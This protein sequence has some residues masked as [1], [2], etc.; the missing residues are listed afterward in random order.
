MS[1]PNTPDERSHPV[2]LFDGVCNLCESTVRFIITR[3]RR[4]QFRFAS[5]QS[6]VAEA[7]AAPFD[8]LP[9]ELSSVLLI[10]D[11]RL[12]SKARAGLRIARRLDGAWPIFYYLFFW[13]PGFIAN[14]VYDFVGNRRYRWFGRKEACWVPTDD[15]RARFLDLPPPGD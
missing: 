6:D 4:S 11:G 5:L 9:D 10:E 2:V 7:L 15:L 3:D 8:D 12:Y 1:G 13:V 14:P